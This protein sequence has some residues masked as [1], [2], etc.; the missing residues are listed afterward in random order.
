MTTK[1]SLI[2]LGISTFTCLFQL[3]FSFITI[4]INKPVKS[5]YAKKQLK[6]NSQLSSLS[7]LP[8]LV[9]FDLD[10][11]LW[12]PEMYTLSEIPNENSKK[13]FKRISEEDNREIIISVASG[14]EYIK[15][16]PAAL[17]VLQ[18]YYMDK[19]PSMRIAAA[20][21]ADTPLAVKIGRAAMQILEVFPGITVRYEN[22]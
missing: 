21:S 10:M 16:F 4:I 8:E 19:Y 6:M 15:L 2:L 9:V 20:S 14:N 17:A 11:C 7:K 1:H 18:D 5:V 3:S 13:I 12:S 22:L